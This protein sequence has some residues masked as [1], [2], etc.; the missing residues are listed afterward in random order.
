[1]E[2]KAIGTND[3]RINTLIYREKLD[4]IYMERKDV[5]I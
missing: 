2:I 3:K 1:M 5:E 4:Q